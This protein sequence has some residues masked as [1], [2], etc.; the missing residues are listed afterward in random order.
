MTDIPAIEDPDLPPPR[1][2]PWRYALIA[3]PLVV[4]GLVFW[5]GYSRAQPHQFSG[6]VIQ[7][8]AAAPDF[9]LDSDRGPVSL[10]DFEGEL[11]MMY[12]GYTFCPDVCPTTLSDIATAVEL[13]DDDDAEQVQLIMVTI[14]PARD[15][16]ARMGDYVRHFDEDFVGLSGSEEE[17]GSVATLYGIYYRAGEGTEATGYLMEHTATV[18]VVDRAGN[19][20]VV[21]PFG[22]EPE[23]IAADL[24]Y[25]LR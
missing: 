6:S 25:M 5:W 15:D 3:L 21:I 22:V 16:A 18:L 7:G 19:L 23:G 1:R 8:T 10:S 13:L 4:A 20:K 17:V 11:V 24:E 12:F 14:D 9:T 2:S